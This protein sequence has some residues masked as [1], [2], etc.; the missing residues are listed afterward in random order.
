MKSEKL[1]EYSIVCSGD[2]ILFPVS[3]VKEGDCREKL[4]VAF[5]E[6]RGLDEY[7]RGYTK[8]TKV[9]LK[10]VEEPETVVKEPAQE[11]VQEPAQEHV[12]EP[13][14]FEIKVPKK[15]TKKASVITIN[16][17]TRKIKKPK[18]ILEVLTA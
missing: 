11:P 10:V 8:R 2:D 9:V 18:S 7:L 16:K 13:E 4:N 15:R 12:Q 6:K 5:N 17:K 3:I 14:V 1:P